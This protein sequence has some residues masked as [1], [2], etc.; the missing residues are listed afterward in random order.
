VLKLVKGGLLL[1]DLLLDI[2]DFLLEEVVFQFK[3]F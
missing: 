3:K 2:V 1:V